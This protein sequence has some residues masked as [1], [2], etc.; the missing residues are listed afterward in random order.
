MNY[1][2]KIIKDINQLNNQEELVNVTWLE[3]EIRELERYP[4]EIFSVLKHLKRFSSGCNNIQVLP[5]GLWNLENLKCLTI[6]SYRIKN[7]PDDIKRLKNLEDITLQ[8]N[9]MRTLPKSIKYLKKLKYI[10]LSFSPNF[11]SLPEEIGYLENLTQI[12]IVKTKLKTLP[13]GIGSLINLEILNV[14]FN[15]IE[16]IPKEI[17]NLKKLKEFQIARNK[18]IIIPKEI[19]GLLS[20]ELFNLSSNKFEY[21]PDEIK[22]LKNLKLLKLQFNDNLLCIP[23]RAIDGLENLTYL[24]VD[25]RFSLEKVLKNDFETEDEFYGYYNLNKYS[26]YHSDFYKNIKLLNLSHHHLEKLPYDIINMHNLREIDIHSN[27]LTH[28]T[29]LISNLIRVRILYLHK[30]KF[31]Y[32]FEKIFKMPK[33]REIVVE[34]YLIPSSILK[35]F[36]INLKYLYINKNYIFPL[37]LK[38]KYKTFLSTTELNILHL[39][40]S[41]RIYRI[42]FVNKK[43]IYYKRNENKSKYTYYDM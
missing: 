27:N 35:D 18:I 22:Y 12:I 21:V 17:C 33:I 29:P 25:E 5:T 39:K 2:R 34:G 11:N 8:F 41:H 32:L 9:E 20:L 16:E 24:I 31:N 15:L 40:T 43:V 26:G 36:S 7:I 19:S 13:K 30:N 10:D 28:L 1:Y 14:S 4:E 23:T 38:G 3:V 37:L 6:N 42:S